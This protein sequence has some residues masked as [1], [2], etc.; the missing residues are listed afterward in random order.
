[1]R[2]QEELFKGVQRTKSHVVPKE[3]KDTQVIDPHKKYIPKAPPESNEVY[4]AR[5]QKRAEKMNKLY[6][7]VGGGGNCFF[8]CMAYLIYGNSNLHWLVR[9]VNNPVSCHFHI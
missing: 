9:K 5:L 4:K 1:M 7:D 3:L 8:H 6:L 2:Q